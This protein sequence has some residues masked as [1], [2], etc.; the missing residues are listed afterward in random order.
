[1]SLA[2]ALAF[3]ACALLPEGRLETHILAVID[4]QAAAWNRGD[5]D[6]YM[7][8]YWRSDELRFVFDGVAC[9]AGTT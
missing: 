8:G 9:A 1:M 3:G 7:A 6:G 4:A 2:A 5:T